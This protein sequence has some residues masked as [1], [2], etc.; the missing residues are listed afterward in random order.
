[1]E[2]GPL[3]HYPSWIARGQMPQ[4]NMEKSHRKTDDSEK[5]SQNIISIY[6][7]LIENRKMKYP[8]YLLTK[9]VKTMQKKNQKP[10]TMQS[11]G[12]VHSPKTKNLLK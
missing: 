7:T 12:M 6:N 3:A 11:E 9:N 8:I 5:A 10:I 4:V 1:M 2:Y